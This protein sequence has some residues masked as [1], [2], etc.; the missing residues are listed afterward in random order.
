MATVP[1]AIDWK[2]SGVIP[3]SGLEAW[4][5][6]EAGHSGH[7]VIFDYSDHNR[8]IDSPV[9]N[10]PAL[11]GNV[12]N[13]QPGWYFNGTD[14]VPLNWTGSITPKHVFILASHEDAAFNLN[15][16]LL[17]GETSGDILSSN[18][19]GTTFF[20]FS[21]PDFEYRKSDVSYIQTNQQ[22]PMSGIPELIEVS[23]ATGSA[24]DGIQVGKQR[25]LAGR[26]WKGYF[27]EQLIYSRVLT[28]AERDRVKLYFNIK[29]AQWRMGIP[30]YF[31]SDDLLDFRRSRFYAEPPQY[32][33][34]TDSYEFEDRGKTF[35]EVADTPPRRWEYDYLS[36]T[37]EQTLIF[38]A[39]W[40]QARIANPF[41]FR[42]KYGT[43][44]SDVRIEDYNRSH[45]AHRS[46]KN[47]IRF[48]L[49]KYP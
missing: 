42:D 35:N 9:L 46:W 39:F 36:R 6:Y 30:L 13:G 7:E 49:I 10:A 15:R 32:D 3:T 38:D 11:V 41:I 18:N 45:D 26:I 29:F 17:S 21:F 25:N 2:N 24:L 28:A 16:G 34:T 43:E 8:T 40:D 1:T 47:D 23:I 33:K 4:H 31:P 44:W 20:N 19:V 14:T 12:L 27:F 48:R 37:A 22:A 5:M